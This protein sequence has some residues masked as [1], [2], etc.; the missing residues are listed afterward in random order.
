MNQFHR[1]PRKI[2]PTRGPLLGDGTPNDSDRAEIGPT[3]LAF[4]EW[5]A[6]GLELP[7]LPRMREYIESLRA[8]WD[9]WQNGTRLNYEGDI[10][11][12]NL[13]IPY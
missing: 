2:D 8:I 3:Q 10:Y 4:D 1:P 9:C 13:M 5:R 6:A 7:N 11:Q 12:F